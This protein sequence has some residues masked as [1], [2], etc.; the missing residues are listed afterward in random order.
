MSKPATQEKSVFEANG[1]KCDY[2]TGLLTMFARKYDE[3][4][5][6]GTK[7]VSKGSNK[8]SDSSDAIE[9]VEEDGGETS[10]PEM[11]RSET[12]H[13]GDVVKREQNNQSPVT[14]RTTAFSVSD[15]LDPRKFTGSQSKR[16]G[17]IPDIPGTVHPWLINKNGELE[18]S[19]D[20]RLR[21]D[22]GL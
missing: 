4:L 12:E 13:P 21:D 7:V 10:A 17:N 5:K 6:A 20:D 1:P 18:E 11:T 22:S 14:Q 19:D 2:R 8:G 3:E 9:S 15:I 16:C